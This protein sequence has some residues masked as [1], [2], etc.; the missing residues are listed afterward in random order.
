M[1]NLCIFLK[2]L[3]VTYTHFVLGDIDFTKKKC[4]NLALLAKKISR[5]CEGVDIRL[6]SFEAAKWFLNF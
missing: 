1:R 3:Q 2:F 4:K 5:A 6:F